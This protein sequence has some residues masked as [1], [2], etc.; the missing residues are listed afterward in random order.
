MISQRHAEVESVVD[1]VAIH[2]ANV[3]VHAGGPQHGSS[4]ASVD[5]Q[6]RPQ[7]AHALRAC[8]KNLIRAK[9]PFY[10][11][12]EPRQS[13]H[14]LTGRIEPGWCCIHSAAAK[15]HVV[16][17]HAC[18]GQRFKQVKNLFPLAEGVHQRRAACPHL[19][20]QKTD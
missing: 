20:D 2:L 9:Q 7:N 17:H 11:F 15:A 12:A 3:I 4:Y 1:P 6:L 19:L 14:H 10:L 8:H 13:G 5:R 18:A 16:H